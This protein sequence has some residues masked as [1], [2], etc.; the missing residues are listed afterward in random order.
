MLDS[1]EPPENKRATHLLLAKPGQN[2]A[3]VC[4]GNL[5][6]TVNLRIAWRVSTT[7]FKRKAWVGLQS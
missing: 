3:Q 4:P 5:L 1:Q 2:W 6:T 7:Y